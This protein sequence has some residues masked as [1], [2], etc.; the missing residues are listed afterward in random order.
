MTSTKKTV[1][2]LST[3]ALAAGAAHGA[4]LYTPINVAI[5]GNTALAFD[6]NQD[7]IPDF[8]IEFSANSAAKPYIAA[9]PAG[10]TS[11]F[12]LSGANMGLPLTPQGTTINGSYQSPQSAGYFNKELVGSSVIPVGGWTAAGNIDGYVGL[13]LTDGTGTH[14]GWAHFI[15]NATDVPAHDNDSGTLTLVDAAMET[16]SGVSIL[17]G[18]TAEVSTAPVAVVPPAPQTGYLGGSARLTVIATGNPNPSFQWKSG[19]V[20]S[21]IYH[22][23][24]L[25]G[26]IT[27][28]FNSDGT[29]NTLI[30]SNLSMADMA[31]YV[32]VISNSSSSITTLPATLTVLPAS[33]SPATLVHRYSFQDQAGSSQFV[34]SVGGPA[35]N[36]SLY[37]DATLTGSSLSLDGTSGTYALLPSGITGDYSQITVEFWADIGNNPPYTRVFAFGDQSGGGQETS[38]VDYSPYEN[39]GYQNLNFLNNNGDTNVY[40]NNNV[41]LT[42]TSND[43]VTVVVDSVNGVMYYY[44]GTNVVCQFHDNNNPIG[45]TMLASSSGVPMSMSDIDD[46]YNTI[47]ASLFGVDPF[48]AG[49]IHEFRIYQ[50]VLSPQAVALNDAVGPANYIQLSAA[51]VISAS[52]GGG[53]ITLSWPAG[54]VNF[55]VQSRPSVAGGSWTTL[56]NVPVLVGTN[57]QTSLPD[58]GTAKFY[59][60][61]HK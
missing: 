46:V 37:G 44:N 4:I 28:A 60:L 20:G 2:F 25:G 53:N 56:T 17:T 7:G 61:I 8:Q 58:S 52:V 45:T 39:G 32:V 48:L 59:Q 12:V 33:D 21:G 34:D 35:W 57:W 6:L 19:A 36:G 42:N 27:D 54:D 29:V 24:S 38:G 15:Y 41:A 18:Q 5:T 3:S 14:Y 47:G 10:T 43:H 30:T 50:G 9:G 31:D 22:N 49:T 23:V 51:P 55:A 16:A 1:A 26:K 13:V 40:A 11:S